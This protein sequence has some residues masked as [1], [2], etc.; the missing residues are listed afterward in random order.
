M[1]VVFFRADSPF[2]SKA[3][4]I[5]KEV[6]VQEQGIPEEE[7]IDGRDPEC[8]HVLLEEDGRPIGAARIRKI[9]DGIYKVERVAVLR[10]KRG[11]GF[12]SFMMKEI[13]RRIVSEGGEK[14]VLNAQ[15]HV[16]GFYERLGYKQVGEVFV[17][18]GIPHV[19]MEKVVDGK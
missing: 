16:K 14:I 15:F 4:Q 7:E 11:K 10:E 19:R 1:R 18:A 8:E 17:E 12:G 3:L 9:G 2:F 6:F 13:E 5:R